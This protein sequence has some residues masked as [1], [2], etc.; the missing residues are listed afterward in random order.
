[1]PGLL[2][3]IASAIVATTADRELFN[4]NRLYVVYPSRIPIFNSTEFYQY[5]LTIADDR[6]FKNGGLG[7]SAAQQGGYQ[8]AALCV[9]LSVACISGVVVG[10]II[11]LPIFGR[12]RKVDDMFHDKLL[13]ILPESEENRVHLVNER[14][15]DNESPNNPP[16]MINM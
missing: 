5:N 10:F 2:S 12:I 14:V 4:G 7:R 6:M 1:M 3:G 15:K 8:I 13:W 11:K 9:T 16:I